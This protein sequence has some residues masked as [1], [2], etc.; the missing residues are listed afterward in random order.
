M[1][2]MIIDDDESIC[3]ILKEMLEM[4]G[5]D[6]SYALTGEEGVRQYIQELPS[7]LLLDLKLPDMDGLAV[8]KEVISFDPDAIVI[9]VT[10]Y[11]SVDSAVGAIRLGAFDYLQ[12][13]LSDD[14]ILVKIESALHNKMLT[15]ELASLKEHINKRFTMSSIVR[16]SEAMAAV[17]EMLQK[18]STYDKP[19]LIRGESGT[20][21]DL[22][23]WA[24]H[25]SGKRKEKP[26]IVFDCSAYPP[27]LV[28]EDLF[29]NT[30]E[31]G[32]RKLGKIKEAS[33]GTLYLDKIEKL[34]LPAQE[35]ILAIHDKAFSAERGA[36]VAISN[37][38]LIASTTT[39]LA[40]LSR[41]GKF[42]RHLY[43]LL[44]QYE[45][46]LPP[47]REREN[48]IPLLAMHF[49]EEANQEYN[50]SISGIESNALRTLLDHSW[51]GNVRELRTVIR[52]ALSTA[53]EKIQDKD[54]KIHGK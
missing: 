46:T 15:K 4:E 23:A 12:K 11:G 7:V 49:V 40:E 3:S 5:Y 10:G 26:M 2:P 29:G 30:H 35:K 43:D 28:E 44:H 37:I 50:C 16:E 36:P 27:N 18:F 41:S 9:M 14:E 38:H 24:V 54:L 32:P 17:V 53:K 51:P 22:A 19:I 20:G 34:A 31:R 6:V 47:L 8:L 25:H 42:N 45:V 48:D 52:A 1:I 21:K 13:P 39:N 33:L